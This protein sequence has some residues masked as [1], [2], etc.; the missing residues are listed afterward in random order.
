MGEF[1]ELQ[2]VLGGYFAEVQGFEKE[3]CVAVSEHYLPTGLESKIPKKPYSIA[4]SLSDKLDSLVGFFG[5]GLKPSSSKDP[6]AL[7]RVALG[8]IRIIIENKRDIKINDLISHS[9][10]NYFDQGFTFSNDLI[11][12]DLINF[13]KE[14]FKYYLKEN[15]IRHDIIESTS[16]IFNLNNI[17]TIFK[18]A[19]SLNK[20]INKPIGMDIVS[21]YK[22]ASS[23]LSSEIKDIK[24]ELSNTTD[25]GIFKNN[26]EKDL[27]NK[28]NELKKHIS[29]ISRDKDFDE[30][31]ML[32]SSAKKEVFDFFDNV[33]VNDDNDVVRKNRLELL[34]FFCKTYETFLDFHQIREIND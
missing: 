24:R 15:S 26:F 29:E 27:Y 19:K 2:G 32:L 5:L 11:F 33:K 25:S 28:T 23:I 12:Q 1:P 22:R 13:L 14:R 3:V 10:N 20:I 18:K 34:N 30:I 7:R 9:I 4:L 21:S 31:L 16:K 8:I 6:Y 17:S